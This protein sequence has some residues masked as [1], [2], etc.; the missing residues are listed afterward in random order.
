MTGT[1][2]YMEPQSEFAKI[3]K[4][5]YGDE[6]IHK[7]MTTV[8]W[9]IKPDPDNP[10]ET[11]ITNQEGDRYADRWDNGSLHLGMNKVLM[12]RMDVVFMPKDCIQWIVDNYD[13]KYFEKIDIFEMP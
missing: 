3:L 1:P 13:P 10:K 11:I 5:C 2:Q 4:A 7:S 12:E 6:Y 9:Q 8:R